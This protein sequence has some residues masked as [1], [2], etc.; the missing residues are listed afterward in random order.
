M[1]YSL[2]L[3]ENINRR[4]TIQEM[5]GN[6]LYLENLALNFGATGPQGPIG[7]P[8]PQ[9]PIGVSGPQGP[10][11]DPGP[12]GPIGDPGPQGPIGD[13]GPQG[14]IGDPGPQGPIGDTGGFTIPYYLIFDDNKFNS[15]SFTLDS[16]NF[17]SVNNFWLDAYDKNNK[18][19]EYLN[20]FYS[21]IYNAAASSSPSLSQQLFM[22][23]WSPLD[24]SNYMIF[25]FN[26][27]S[28]QVTSGSGVTINKP[29]FLGGGL[30]S[31]SA[32]EVYVSF[33]LN[34]GDI[35][36]QGPSG[37]IG[38]TYGSVTL[39]S[40]SAT[41]EEPSITSDS[42]VMVNLKT[43]SNAGLTVFYTGLPSAGSVVLSALQA[44]GNLNA[45]DGSS[46]FY[47]IIF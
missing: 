2:I 45:L 6:F 43:Y 31:K 44:D 12:Q 3:R 34:A 32:T 37:Q 4:L 41:V 14:P 5:D 30:V 46:L 33:M 22:K 42:V 10:I 40:G 1:T 19:L 18:D 35:G 25:S 17:T 29:T 24:Y 28:F 36:Q 47:K 26:I 15:N 11:G 20:S 13:P 16:Q 8:G 7:D 39:V 9:G 23:I 27:N 38:A 21:A